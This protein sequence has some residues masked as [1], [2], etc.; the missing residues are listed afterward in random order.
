MGI[1]HIKDCLRVCQ[2]AGVNAFVIGTHGA[3][4][5]TAIQQLW[6]EEAVKRHGPPDTVGQLNVSTG[7]DVRLLSTLD[8]RKVSGLY[9][10]RDQYR[11]C[12]ISVPN[13]TLE[14]MV[15]MPHVVDHD[16]RRFEAYVASYQIAAATGVP[17]ETVYADMCRDLGIRESG[18]QDLKYLRMNSLLPPENHAGG[19]VLL[20]DEMNRGQTEVAQAWMQLIVSGTYLDYALPDD[21]WIVTTMNPDDSEYQVRSLDPALLNRG[22]VFVYYPDVEEFLTWAKAR[23]LG[24]HTRIFADKHRRFINARENA[25]QIRSGVTC[26]NRSLELLDRAWAVMTREEV[27]T[28]GQTIAAGLIGPDAGALYY[29]EATEAVH[30]PL[31]AKEV[32]EDYGWK[33]EMSREELRDYK[34]WP[35]T[36][37]RTRLKA[38][39]KKTNVKTELL[40][41]TLD[42]VGAWITEFDKELA[43]RGA[44]RSGDKLSD[45]EKGWVL[46]LGLFLTDIPADIARRFLLDDMQGKFSRTMYWAGTYPVFK[47]LAKRVSKDYEEAEQDDKGSR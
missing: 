31:R 14:E 23:G 25:G 34:S 33:K 30:R 37:V 45:Q 32:V 36:Q 11:F 47:L 42:E 38:Q 7:G 1:S 46:N 18:G 44:D 4:K 12:Q 39:I 5:T 43:S 24:E 29:K 40:K 35:V 19:G 13:L 20:A 6:L 10:A 15:G 16:K 17:R 26:T 27:N 41:V 28:V 21:F 9:T 8:V 22:A 3:G 2:R